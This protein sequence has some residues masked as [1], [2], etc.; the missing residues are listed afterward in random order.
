MNIN[1]ID[2]KFRELNK[3]E[4]YLHAKFEPRVSN[5]EVKRHLYFKEIKNDFV[6]ELNTY[7]FSPF[8][9]SIIYQ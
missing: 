7:G 4:D 8:I 5:S 9:F 1:I 2:K 3:V 6:E